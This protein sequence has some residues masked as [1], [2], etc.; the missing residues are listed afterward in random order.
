M[1]IGRRIDLSIIHP[2]TFVVLTRFHIS[3]IFLH[4]AGSIRIQARRRESSLFQARLDNVPIM[5]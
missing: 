5:L 1:I 2:S 3:L 4:R